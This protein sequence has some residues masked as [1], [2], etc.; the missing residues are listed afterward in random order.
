MR[1][2]ITGAAGMLGADLLIA[3]SAAGHEAVPF[4]HADLDITDGATVVRTLSRQRPEAVINCAAWTDVDGAEASPDAAFAVNGAG[5][6]E[7]ARAAAGAGAWVVHISSDYVFAGDKRR[8]YL[9]SDPVAPRSVYGKSK[10][11]GELAVAEAAPEAHTIVRS[12]WLFGL[13]GRCFPATILRL[14]AERDG[15][16]VVDDQVGCPTFTRHLAEALVEIAST[17]PR[18]TVHVA[19]SGACSWHEFAS[20]IVEDAGLEC[21][22]RPAKSADMAR[23]AARPAYSVLGSERSEAPRLPD[24]R[25]GLGAYLAARAGDKMTVGTER[26]GW[27]PA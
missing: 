24:W 10:L 7:L 17:R 22:L 12:S 6:G 11:A 16:D 15:L 5:A 2:L 4:S 26:W 13:H 25:Q 14:A 8:P 9:E 21:E 23:P 3:A 27:D 1:L 18:G 19:G 20:A